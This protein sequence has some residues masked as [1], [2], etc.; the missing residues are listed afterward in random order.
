MARQRWT[1]A[2]SLIAGLGFVAMFAAVTFDAVA[3]MPNGY[4]NQP[5]GFTT[6]HAI[7]TPYGRG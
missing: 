2:G 1:T 6:M 4:A 5:D 3:L 7:G